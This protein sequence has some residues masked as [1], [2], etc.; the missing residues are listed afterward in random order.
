ARDVER[1]APGDAWHVADLFQ[2]L[3]VA[4][5]AGEGPAAAAIHHQLLTLGD[6]AVRHIGDEAGVRIAQ[7]YPRRLLGHLDDAVA[8]RLAAAFGERQA[9]VAADIPYFRS[10][11]RR[12]DLPR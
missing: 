6:R 7:R 10:A 8:E 4:N 5:A 2:V 1:R 9:H 3:P 11:K 12:P